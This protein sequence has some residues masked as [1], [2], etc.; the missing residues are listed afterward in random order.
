MWI[1]STDVALD[2][3]KKYGDMTIVK[4]WTKVCNILKYGINLKLDITV[5]MIMK[6]IKLNVVNI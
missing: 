2:L 4:F 6:I 1:F 5:Q 3:Q